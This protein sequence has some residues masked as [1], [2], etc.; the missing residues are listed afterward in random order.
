[1]SK[2]VVLFLCTGNSARSQMAEALLRAEAGDLFEV[3]SAGTEPKEVNPLTVKT[4]AEMGVDVSGQRSKHLKELLGRLPVRILIVVCAEAEKTCP[5]IWPGAMHRLFWRFD[6]PAAAEGSEEEKLRVF[7]SV[8]D[9]IHSRIK[10]WLAEPGT[11]SLGM[12][13]KIE[14]ALKS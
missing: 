13:V 7:R 12:K 9:Q 4:M 1:M 11:A 3:H 5:V 10:Q 8:R 6:D 14:S 2:P